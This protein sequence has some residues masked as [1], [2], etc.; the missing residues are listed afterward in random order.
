M[1]SVYL[2]ARGSAPTV[3]S[4]EAGCKAAR[5]V[6][7]RASQGNCCPKVMRLLSPWWD[8]NASI[9]G[10]SRAVRG[11]FGSPSGRDRQESFSTKPLSFLFKIT[12]KNNQISPA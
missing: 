8:L 9:V 3:Y 12:L 2:H 6:R 4:Q 11:R 10:F 1:G 5:A 7:F